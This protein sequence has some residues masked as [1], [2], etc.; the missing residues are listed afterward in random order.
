MTLPSEMIGG[1]HSSKVMMSGDGGHTFI[2]TSNPTS[3]RYRF[4]EIVWCARAVCFTCFYVF[5]VWTCLA[6]LLRFFVPCLC[7]RV[8]TR[9][10]C[11][12]GLSQIRL[13]NT[14]YVW[15]FL[16]LSRCHHFLQQLDDIVWRF[17]LVAIC[18]H[19]F[20]ETLRAFSTRVCFKCCSTVR[21]VTQGLACQHQLHHL[22]CIILRGCHMFL[23][24]LIYLRGVVWVL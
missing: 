16:C 10:L 23:F 11:L 24:A 15:A 9:V 4:F 12:L 6:S 19:T 8:C 1:L 13:H 3:P 17:N 21:H 18:Q 7:V 2:D 22:A 5:L 14:K 20:G